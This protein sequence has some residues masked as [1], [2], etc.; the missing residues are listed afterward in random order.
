MIPMQKPSARV[1][2]AEHEIRPETLWV[3]HNEVLPGA[4]TP[5]TEFDKHVLAG[6]LFK[7]G[8]LRS[9]D[10]YVL[11]LLAGAASVTTAV[12]GSGG[13]EHIDGDGN[14][15]ED[16]V[17]VDGVWWAREDIDAKTKKPIE[18]AVRLGQRE[19]PEETKT[20][21]PSDTSAELDLQINSQSVMKGDV[22]GT[23]QF[24]GVFFIT[25]SGD[26][27]FTI[28]KKFLAEGDDDVV[29]INAGPG[30][31]NIEVVGKGKGGVSVDQFTIL[32]LP[33]VHNAAKY[34]PDPAI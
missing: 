5:T 33:S 3:V 30:D 9:G 4:N 25:V 18:G 19:K 16:A 8:F 28:R 23:T 12:E 10:V 34:T 14:V 31:V 21:V 17:E 22:S 7:S 1:L 29:T 20:E 26:N 15:V 13:V 2:A 24:G 6:R 32:R 11:M 27:R